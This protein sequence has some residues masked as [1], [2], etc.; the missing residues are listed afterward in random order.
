MEVNDCVIDQYGHLVGVVT[1]ASPYSSRVTTILD[2]ALELGG[3]VAR[4]DEDAVLEGIS[5]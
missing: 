3:R 4:T 2:P 1:E 5:P